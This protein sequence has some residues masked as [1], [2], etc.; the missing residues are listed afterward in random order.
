MKEP[1]EKELV[2]WDAETIS[3]LNMDSNCVMMEKVLVV[4]SSEFVKLCGFMR[5]LMMGFA[6]EISFL[7]K[8]KARNL[9]GERKP[10]S[11]SWF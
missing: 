5:V 9:K 1:V 8:L 10:A 3:L 4:F 6:M 11:S 7:K 2:V